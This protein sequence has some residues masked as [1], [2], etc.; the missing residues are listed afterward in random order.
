MTDCPLKWRG[1][2]HV[3]NFYIMDLGNF[4]TTS[5]R[6]IQVLS[7]NSSTVGVWITPMLNAQVYY[8]L[9]LVDCNPLTP[10]LRFVLDLSYKLFLH[11]YAAVG[12]IST[13]TSRRA[14]RLR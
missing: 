1:Q 9:T 12:R 8:K 2:G 6:C 11:C 7:T 4:A 13:D 10:L 14:F 5:R 3:S